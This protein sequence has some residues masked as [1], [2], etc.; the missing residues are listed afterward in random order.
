MN[1]PLASLS[2]TMASKLKMKI[3]MTE[4]QLLMMAVALR[5]KLKKDGLALLR[6]ERSQYAKAFLEME[7]RQMMKDVM[8][9]IP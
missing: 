7:S 2:P 9:K 4:I 5:E 3:A 6:L 1:L 8:I